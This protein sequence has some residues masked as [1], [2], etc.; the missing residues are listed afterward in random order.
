MSVVRSAANRRVR[1]TANERRW[2]ANYDFSDSQIQ[3][4]LIF[5]VLL[6]SVK[7]SVDIILLRITV[8]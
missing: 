3:S 1:R 4:L 5:F 2:I 6:S 7:Q 8:I